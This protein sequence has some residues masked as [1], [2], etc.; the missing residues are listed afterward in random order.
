MPWEGL[1][2]FHRNAIFFQDYIYMQKTHFVHA[3][4]HTNFFSPRFGIHTVEKYSEQSALQTILSEQTFFQ[5]ISE[6]SICFR[7]SYS[8]PRPPIR[9]CL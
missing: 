9:S 3:H 7:D 5:Q 4:S 1:E 6:Q 2:L 8:H